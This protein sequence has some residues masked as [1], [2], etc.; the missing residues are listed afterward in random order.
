MYTLIQLWLA[1]FTKF[2]SLI[3]SNASYC[4]GFFIFISTNQLYAEGS[5]R[6]SPIRIN[7]SN[8][9]KIALLTVKNESVSDSLAQAELYKWEQSAEEDLLTISRDILVSPPIFKLK[10]KTGQN[11]R[12]GIRVKPDANVELA[13]RIKIFE[14]PVKNQEAS[15][16]LSVLVSFSVPIFVTPKGFVTKFDSQWHA[17][18]VN[19]NLKVTLKNLGNTHEQIKTIDIYEN[20]KLIASTTNMAYVLPSKERSWLLDFKNKLS[21]KKVKLVALTD[22]G[23]TEMV[24]TI[25]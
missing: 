4:I 16:G 12:L 14:V 24:L 23:L 1:S 11:V 21:A 2:K 17:S 22:H 7:F 18:I 8:A 9:E 13:Y 5:I 20:E 15:N 19:G 25:D 3:Q 6:V 10:S